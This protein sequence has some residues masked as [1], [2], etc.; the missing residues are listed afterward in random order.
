[1]D[2]LVVGKRAD[3]IVLNANPLDHMN[4]TRNISA[5]YVD[6]KAIDRAGMRERWAREFKAYDSGN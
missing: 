4:N 5:V 6:G 1:M 2:S 3:F